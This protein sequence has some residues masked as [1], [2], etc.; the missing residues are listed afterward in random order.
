[1]VALLAYQDFI[2]YSAVHA[3]WCINYERL[4]RSGQLAE[5]LASPPG[6]SGPLRLMDALAPNLDRVL[7]SRSYAAMAVLLLE[8]AVLTYM[9][10]PADK[11]AKQEK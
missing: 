6:T 1:M 5:Y 10:L 3:R 7:S 2:A 4:E 9:A 8:S 11:M